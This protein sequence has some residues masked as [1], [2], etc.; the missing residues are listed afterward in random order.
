MFDKITKVTDRAFD[1]VAKSVGVNYD[2][3]LEIYRSLKPEHFPLL[4]KK[5]GMDNVVEYVSEM[6][7]KSVRR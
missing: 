6:E 1:R 7:R 3:D 5:Y 2:Q 4:V